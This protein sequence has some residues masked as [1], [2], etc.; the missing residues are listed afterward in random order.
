MKKLRW[1]IL[2]TANIAQQWLIPALQ[3]S[4]H[5]QVVAVAS[6]DLKRANDCATR[7]AIEHVFASY[8]ALLASDLI[9]AVY[10]PLPNHLHLPY[11]LQALQAGKHVLCEKPLGLDEDQVKQLISCAEQHPRQLLMEAFMYRF[12][13]QW[14]RALAMIHAGELGTIK[15]VNSNFTFFNRDPQNVRNQSGMG[16]GS[17]MDVGCYCVSAART[18]FGREPIRVS[19]NIEIDPDFGVDRHVSG[20]LDF[21]PGTATFYC[22]TQSAP[23]QQVTVIGEQATLIIANPF[24]SRDT[25]SKLIFRQGN[26]DSDIVVKQSNHYIDQVDA[27]ATAVQQQQS[28][29]NPLSDAL[30]NMRVLDALVQSSSSHWVAIEPRKRS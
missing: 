27:F 20:I 17:L 6:R 19:A 26:Q 5:N 10:I 4:H 28:S 9:D 15:S 24:Y 7:F 30:A 3:K 16:G 2:S 18:L 21:A 14:Q 23:S 12:H 11:C 8:E 25:P 1:G 22:S 29:P 13:P